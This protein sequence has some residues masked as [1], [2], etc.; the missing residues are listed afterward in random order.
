MFFGQLKK[1]N[2]TLI[3]HEIIFKIIS[4]S[5]SLKDIIKTDH[6]RHVLLEAKYK[7]SKHPLLSLIIDYVN[8]YESSRW[9]WEDG[10]LF[11]GKTFYGAERYVFSDTANDVKFAIRNFNSKENDYLESGVKVYIDNNSNVLTYDESLIMLQIM[12]GVE[13]VRHNLTKLKIQ[14]NDI[15]NRQKIKGLYK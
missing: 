11:R 3:W 5:Y 9:Q 14:Q 8:D 15:H 4:K 13:S 10:G 1:P 2:S 12:R 6:D 7:L